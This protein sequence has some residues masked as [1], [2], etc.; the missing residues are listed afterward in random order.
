MLRA[1]D[2]STLSLILKS[3]SNVIEEDQSLRSYIKWSQQ[4]EEEA[5]FVREV[6]FKAIKE[7][8]PLLLH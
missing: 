1:R 8:V 5:S 7:N 2:F 6:P 4:R 3:L